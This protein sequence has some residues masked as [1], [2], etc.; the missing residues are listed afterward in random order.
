MDTDLVNYD[1]KH[2][3][4]LR[5]ELEMAV[6]AVVTFEPA[7]TMQFFKDVK[8]YGIDE[9]KTYLLRFIDKGYHSPDDLAEDVLKVCKV[10]EKIHSKLGDHFIP[11]SSY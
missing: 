2:R 1:N 11:T 5:R 3:T 7:Y 4:S 6:D 8:L 9:A 10:I